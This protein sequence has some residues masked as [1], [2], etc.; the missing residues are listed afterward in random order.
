M[1]TVAI[2]GYGPRGECVFGRFLK[3]NPNAKVVAIAETQKDRRER[4]KLAFD[5]PDDCV[6]NSAEEFFAREKLCDAVVVSTDDLTHV[7]YAKMAAERKYHILLE[8]PI[9]K[10]LNECDELVEAVKRN[11]VLTT[12]CHELR[13]GA[14]Y[15]TV[16]NLL[17]SGIIGT[18]IHVMQVENVGYWHQAHSFVRGCWR[19]EETS[20]PMILA[21]CCHD[22]DLMCW[23]MDGDPMDTVSSFG[24]LSYFKKENKPEGATEFCLGGCAVKA[25]CP[26]DCEKYY[27][28]K[29]FPEGAPDYVKNS[30][31]LVFTITPKAPTEE[32]VYEALRSTSYGRCVFDSDNDVVDHQIVNVRY[33]SGATGSLLMTAF[34]SGGSNLE[35][36]NTRIFGTKGEI[37]FGFE[38]QNI[39]RVMEFGKSD[40]SI[41]VTE[42]ADVLLYGH[43]AADRNLVFK[44]VEAVQA[45]KDGSNEDMG[46]SVEL[47]VVSHKAALAAEKSRLNGGMPVKL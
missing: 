12:V 42:N 34:T 33:K 15:A 13:Y 35:G 4:G 36:R 25:D 40:R 10:Y 18:P 2:I 1:V 32:N 3:E 41:D 11:G 46:S 21:K 14:A 44:F 45:R 29:G 6:Y 37:Q 28:R 43:D 26:W 8:K 30:P 7:K 27:L 19:K 39:V 23:L 20:S 31:N 5:L 22:L 38:G 47:S 9:T 24:E 16:K 17:Q